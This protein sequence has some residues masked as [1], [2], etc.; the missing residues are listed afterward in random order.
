MHRISV[1]VSKEL[2]QMFGKKVPWSCRGALVRSLLNL[3]LSKSNYSEII[4]D[5]CK[6]ENSYTRYD[7]VR[8]VRW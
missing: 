2:L 5:L 3:V 4:S 6:S 1:P 7:I 8:K